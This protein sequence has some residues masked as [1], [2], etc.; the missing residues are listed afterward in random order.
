MG[1]HHTIIIYDVRPKI[2]SKGERTTH[3]PTE[4]KLYTFDEIKAQFCTSFTAAERKKCLDIFYS[5]MTKEDTADMIIDIGKEIRE[6]PNTKDW[7]HFDSITW[8]VREAWVRG[9]M[10]ANDLMA[11]SSIYGFLALKGVKKEDI[12]LEMIEAIEE[13][14]VKL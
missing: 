4:E 2:K 5:Q 3:M 9:A 1:E 13:G 12:T 14:T 6:N 8:T 10:F 11:K 7:T